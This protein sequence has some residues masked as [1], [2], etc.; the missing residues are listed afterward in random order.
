MPLQ[1]TFQEHVCK[2]RINRPSARNAINFELMDKFEELLTRLENDPEIRVFILAG[3]GKSFISGGDLREFHQ[4]QKAGPAMKMGKRMHNILK[5][6]EELPAWTV[7]AIN[8][9]AYGGGWEIMLAFDFRIA[10]EDAVFGFTQGKFYLPPGWGGLTRL[11]KTV[12][13]NRALWLLATRQ[14]LNADEALKLGL[15]HHLCTHSSFDESLESLVQKLTTNDRDFIRR[16]KTISDAERQAYHK[17]ISDELEPFGYFWEHEE[18][19][20]R[21]QEFLNRKKNP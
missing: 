11:K 12:G 15:V 4:I 2:A 20:S 14:V 1:V 19:I 8:G 7:A 3:T 10:V 5:R 13:R 9:L 6:I 16:L 17:N 21:V 18:H